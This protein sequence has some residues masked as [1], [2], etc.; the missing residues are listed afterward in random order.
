MATKTTTPTSRA[1]RR[2]EDAAKGVAAEAKTKVCSRC[3][4]RKPLKSF[5]KNSAHAD[6][7]QS[8]C[9]ECKQAREAGYRAAKKAA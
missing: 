7:M 2:R 5:N 1:V 3:G 4:K 6:G 8:D 9:R